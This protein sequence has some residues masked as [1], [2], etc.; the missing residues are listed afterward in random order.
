MGCDPRQAPLSSRSLPS[1]YGSV[2]FKGKTSHH[3]VPECVTTAV[4]ESFSPSPKV[5]MQ[6]HFCQSGNRLVGMI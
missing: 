5:Y 6:C 4:S 1:K 3:S 2:P